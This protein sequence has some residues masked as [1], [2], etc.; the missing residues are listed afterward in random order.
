MRYTYILLSLTFLILQ[1]SGSSQTSDLLFQ[2]ALLKENGEGNL[3]AAV[4]LYERI[5]NDT[6]AARGVR[7]K[8]QLHIGMCWEKLGKQEARSAY[9]HIIEYYSDQSEIVNKAKERL[10][11]LQL[12]QNLVLPDCADTQENWTGATITFVADMS[13]SIKTGV[14]DP[15]KHHVEVCGHFNGFGHAD[16]LHPSPNNPMFYECDVFMKYSIGL[17][18]E[19]RFRVLPPFEFDEGGWE[20]NGNR[21]FNMPSNDLRMYTAHPIFYKRHQPSFKESGF[22]AKS[23]YSGLGFPKGLAVR[24][25]NELLVVNKM[26]T[27]ASGVFLARRGRLSHVSDCFSKVG[28]PFQGPDDIVIAPSGVVLVCVS[29]TGTIYKIPSVGGD[30]KPFITR[31]KINAKYFGPF[32]LEIAPVGFDGPNV[33]PGDLIVADN[34]YGTDERAIWAINLQTGQARVVVGGK[35]H[36]T[37]GPLGAVFNSKAELYIAENNDTGK[38]RIVKVTPDGKVIPVLTDIPKICPIAIHPQTDEIYLNYRE[39]EIYKLNE[40]TK[41]LELFASDLYSFDMIFSPDGK[42]L[43]ISSKTWEDIIEITGP[44][45][46]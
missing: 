14:F 41:A 6:T 25:N 33:D 15:Q 22:S 12:D 17:F 23:F 10:G 5:V 3:K 32:N 27:P 31:E 38:S 9:Q 29:N 19:F 45:N 24:S 18:I 21:Y 20:K 7:A 42:S 40:K 39:G 28:G 11:R 44:F 37:N 16:T 34:A 4:E 35:K 1:S 36:F 26:H 30:P 46:Q 13:E 43:F 8:A 2:Q